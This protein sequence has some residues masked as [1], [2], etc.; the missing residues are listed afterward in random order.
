MKG[1]VPLPVAQRLATRI[2]EEFRRLPLLLS[3]VEVAGSVRREKSEVGDLEIVARAGREYNE[4]SMHGVLEQLHIERGQPNRAG[5][6]A[7]WGG[8][9][10]RGVARVTDGLEVGVDLFV[11][12]PPAEWGPIYAI[13]TGSAAFSQ[14]V[15][16]RLHRYG[17]ECRDGRLT[18]R[19][20][21][22]TVPCPSEEV[23]FSAARLPWIP[24]S[25]RTID[26][27][28]FARI[29][30]REWDPHATYYPPGAAPPGGG[31]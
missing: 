27:P 2:S 28:D 6:R 19:G 26:G 8:R 21:G 11:V 12:Y 10:Y 15:V 29:W 20:G 17:F 9:Y 3:R 7:P 5:A 30:A 24:P 18:R 13:R 4:C 23:F 16:T 25:L 1:R 22:A 14:A 31:P